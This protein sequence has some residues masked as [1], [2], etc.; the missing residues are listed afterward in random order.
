MSEQPKSSIIPAS[1]LDTEHAAPPSDKMSCRDYKSSVDLAR[2]FLSYTKESM[3]YKS[4]SY[5]VT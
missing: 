3:L 5:A 4:I 2:L 1:L